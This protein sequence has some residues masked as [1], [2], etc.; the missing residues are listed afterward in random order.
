MASITSIAKD[1]IAIVVV[2]IV[3]L[4]LLWFFIIK[5][6]VNHVTPLIMQ[7]RLLG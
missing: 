1:L 7:T 6:L 3:A 2:K 4:F 5:P